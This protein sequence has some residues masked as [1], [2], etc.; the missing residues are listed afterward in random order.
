MAVFEK[1]NTL[2]ISSANEPSVILDQLAEA[3]EAENRSLQ[4]SGKSCSIL[5]IR[6]QML[7]G[8]VLQKLMSNQR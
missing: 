1:A 7:K 6:I 8:T 3:Q 4:N 2:V 5:S